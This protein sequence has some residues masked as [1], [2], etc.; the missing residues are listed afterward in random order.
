MG[1]EEWR[2]TRQKR[3]TKQQKRKAKVAISVWALHDLQEIARPNDPFLFYQDVEEEIEHTTAAKLEGF[4]TMKT[5]PIH[6]S[7]SKWVERVKS[8]VKSIVEWIK[9]RRK[10]NR[11]IIERVEK[12]IETISDTKHTRNQRK[13]QKEETVQYIPQ[14]DKHCWVVLYP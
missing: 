5:R 1:N 13:K 2:S 10:N 6:N 3:K 11:E 14:W 8:R 7:L 9:T 4:I 12:N